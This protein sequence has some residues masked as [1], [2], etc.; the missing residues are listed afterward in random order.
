MGRGWRRH[1]W[2]QPVEEAHTS[3]GDH[4]FAGGALASVLAAGARSV[5]GRT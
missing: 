5:V 3:V 1:E 4:S 2:S